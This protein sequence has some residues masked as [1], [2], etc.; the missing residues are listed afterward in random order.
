[1]SK[2]LKTLRNEGRNIQ[3]VIAKRLA[4]NSKGLGWLAAADIAP[5]LGIVVPSRNK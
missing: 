3:Q 1:M 4:S 2:S 5:K